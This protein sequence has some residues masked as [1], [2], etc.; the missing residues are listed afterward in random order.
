MN[1]SVDIRTFIQFY[2]VAIT[3][4]IKLCFSIIYCCM[5]AKDFQNFRMQ[6]KEF[7]AP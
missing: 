5:L 2:A 6:S 3:K 1:C 7:L 4:D